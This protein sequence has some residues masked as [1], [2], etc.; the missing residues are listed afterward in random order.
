MFYKNPIE[1]D[2]FCFSLKNKK[3][4]LFEFYSGLRG[5]HVYE[6]SADWRPYEK[7]KV[8]LKREDKQ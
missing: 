2:S 6:N 3:E 1:K 7:E 5:Y 4:N 8:T